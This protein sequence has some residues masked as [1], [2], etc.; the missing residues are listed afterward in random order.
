MIGL[1]EYDYDEVRPYLMLLQFLLSN[2]SPNFNQKLDTALSNYLDV[3]RQNANFYKYMETM[4]EFIF[5]IT[6]R[7][8]HVRNWFYEK[9]NQWEW[10]SDWIKEYKMPPNPIA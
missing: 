5:K 9:K 7:I 1:T 4:F 2:P 6:S 8:P 3:V 10:L